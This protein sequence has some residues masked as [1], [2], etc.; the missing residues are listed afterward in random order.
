MLDAVQLEKDVFISN[1]K[2]KHL[3][4]EN[5]QWIAFSNNSKFVSTI[6]HTTVKGWKI[7][8]SIAG[9]Y[10]TIDDGVEFNPVR[11]LVAISND[12]TTLI[13]YRG[14]L[15]FTIYSIEVTTGIYKK[16]DSIDVLREVRA[17]VRADFNMLSDDTVVDLRFMKDQKVFRVGFA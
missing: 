13:V 7:N 4:A 5:V 3:H 14:E 9:T 17:T 11:P 1:W 10:V 6:C 2:G 8:G 15:V 12:G 16:K